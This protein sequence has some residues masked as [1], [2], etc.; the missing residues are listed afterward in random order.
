MKPILFLLALVA[1]LTFVE[2]GAKNEFDCIQKRFSKGCVHST[3]LYGSSQSAILLG[4]YGQKFE[5][6]FHYDRNNDACLDREEWKKLPNNIRSN[7]RV[8][9]C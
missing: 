4:M 6:I 7:L 8:V 1:M 3:D 9:F 2:A 5:R